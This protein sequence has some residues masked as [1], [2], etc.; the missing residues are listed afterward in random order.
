MP[1]RRSSRTTFGRRSIE[2]RN[3]I[4]RVES[5]GGKSSRGND[6]IGVDSGFGGSI[7]GATD[8]VDPLREN[9]DE[10]TNIANGAFGNVGAFAHPPRP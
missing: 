5:E 9:S 7:S 3:S 2:G 8:R 10:T 4:D 6:G 1:S